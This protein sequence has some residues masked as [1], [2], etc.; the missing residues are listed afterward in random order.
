MDHASVRSIERI[1]TIATA[2]V[3]TSIRK[4]FSDVSGDTLVALDPHT[5][6]DIIRMQELDIYEG[7][8]R[9][10]QVNQDF[11]NTI[12]PHDEII[13]RVNEEQCQDDRALPNTLGFQDTST[14]KS[15]GMQD[16]VVGSTSFWSTVNR[17]EH[18]S[19]LLGDALDIQ[20]AEGLLYQPMH[21]PCVGNYMARA[22]FN[23]PK[24]PFRLFL[25]KSPHRSPPVTNNEGD[26]VLPLQESTNSEHS[27]IESRSRSGGTI[28]IHPQSSPITL[29][30]IYISESESK[31]HN[32]YSLI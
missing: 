17:Q 28:E 24:R 10:Y 5:I 23:T 11:V 14:C 6:L 20:N 19:I 21:T 16:Q 4:R 22:Q 8:E 1:P 18:S 31:S 13:C 2:L 9:P 30:D 32:S 27:S 12:H 7:D 25:H 3:P 29:S 15:G 26:S